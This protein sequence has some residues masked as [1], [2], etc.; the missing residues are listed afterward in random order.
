MEGERDVPAADPLGQ[1]PLGADG[2]QRG[3]APVAA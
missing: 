3:V 1:R 2:R